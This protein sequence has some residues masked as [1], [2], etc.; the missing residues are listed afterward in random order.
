MR[1]F[2]AAIVLVPFVY[3][4]RKDLKQFTKRDYLNIA[5]MGFSSMFLFTIF[6]MYGMK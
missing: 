1:M 3:K 5:C 4:Y 2:F 6:M